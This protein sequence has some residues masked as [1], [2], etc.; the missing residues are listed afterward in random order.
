MALA[1]RYDLVKLLGEGS[2]GQVF[3]ALDRSLGRVVAVKVLHRQDNDARRRFHREG[4][5][6]HSQMENE[7]VVG[8]LDHT[9]LN[10]EDPYLV[11]EFCELGSLRSWVGMGRGWRDVVTALLHAARGLAGIHLA[12]TFHRDIKP[13]N[14]LVARVQVGSGW[15]VKL[16]DFGLAGFP[17]AVTGKMTRSA[18]GT[19]GYMA[20]EILAGDEFHPPADIYSLGVVG[21]ELLTGATHVAAL[22]ACRAPDALK[23]L[24]QSMVSG[25]ASARPT[26]SDVVRML[27]VLLQTTT[28]SLPKP[29]HHPQPGP[30]V[31]L[32]QQRAGMSSTLA[33]SVAA[34]GLGAILLGI[35]SRIGARNGVYYDSTVDRNRGG[36][37]RFRRG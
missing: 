36:D 8:L 24:I 19:E 29:S 15:K 30:T 14:M 1:D 35:V 25:R 3:R 23:A 21:V 37:G 33:T 34:V 4:V 31:T 27:T 18:G 11:L 7:F 16:A 5:I 2:F 13:E 12:G 6:L 28:V 9:G 17:H 10:D 26:A 22:H 32:P 20:P